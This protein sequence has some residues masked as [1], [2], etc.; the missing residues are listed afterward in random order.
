MGI[1]TRD[2]AREYLRLCAS[3]ARLT[4]DDLKE[5]GKVETDDDGSVTAVRTDAFS[6]TEAIQIRE[7]LKIATL[8]AL[9]YFYEHRE[10]ADHHA[11]N[12]TL[13]S[14]LFAVRER[15]MY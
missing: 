13:R 15:R 7:M 5:L 12:M 4:E 9:A 10:D 2:M 14:I 6:V 1:I 8:Y 3:V 11:L